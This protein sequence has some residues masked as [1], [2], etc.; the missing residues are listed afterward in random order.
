MSVA[1]DGRGGTRL[2]AAAHGGF[3]LVGPKERVTAIGGELGAGPR[4]G[5]GWEV[6]ALFPAG[7]VLAPPISGTDTFRALFAVQ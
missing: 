3:G 6:R 1:D 5:A 2:P 4:D 7:E